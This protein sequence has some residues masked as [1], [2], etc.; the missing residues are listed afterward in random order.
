MILIRRLL[1]RIRMYVVCD[2][3]DNSVTFSRKLWK[4]IERN[5]L[6]EAKVFTFAIPQERVFAFMLNPGI[7][8][9]AHMA[10]IQYNGKYKTIGYESLNPTVNYIFYNYGLPHD[11]PC[12]LSVAKSKLNEKWLY[13]ILPPRKTS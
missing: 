9:E 2:P 12:K 6:V 1:D 5:G 3:R 11:K 10:D 8:T 13:R 4:H 7:K